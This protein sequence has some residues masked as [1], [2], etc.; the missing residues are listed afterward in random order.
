[1]A[2]FILTLSCRDV[3]GIV[4]A[5]S[6]FLAKHSGFIK[7]STQ[8]G[9]PVTQRFFMR[10]DFE[11]GTNS[12]DETAWKTLFESEIATPFKMDWHL[13]NASRKQR[14]VILVSNMAIASMIWCIGFVQARCRLRLRR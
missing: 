14:V 11:T 6:A 3:H 5:V 10:V 13:H 9:D 7:E 2:R 12:P 4:A 1:M 8:Y